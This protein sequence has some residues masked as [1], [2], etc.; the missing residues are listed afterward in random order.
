M[1]DPRLDDDRS[2]VSPWTWVPGALFIVCLVSAL[3]I[4]AYSSGDLPRTAGRSDPDATT[5][6]STPK[7]ARPAPI[8]AAPQ[9]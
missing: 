5:G 8:P 4:W 6:Q 1:T 7:P 2:G 3:S 9:R